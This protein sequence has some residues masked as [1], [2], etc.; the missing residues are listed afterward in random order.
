MAGLKLFRAVTGLAVV[1]A[2]IVVVLG[3]YVRLSAAGLGC[4]DWPGCYG[5][6]SAAQ[7]EA[8]A[9]R[10]AR[11]FPEQP[12]QVDKAAKE[13]LHRYAAGVLGLLVL[14]VALL[15]W[16][17]GRGRLLPLLLVGLLLFQA[18]L[19]MWTVTLLLKPLVVSAHLLGGMALLALLWWMLLD[20]ASASVSARPATL[21][22]TAAG[23][24]LLL[25]LGQILLGGWTS[26]N[27]AGLACGGFPACNGD[28]WP[29]ADYAAAV[30]VT[31][32][33]GPGLVAIH[34]L[35][36]LGALLL[37]LLYLGGLAIVS[38]RNG[39]ALRRIG[40]AIGLLLMLQLALG[41]GNVVT[42]LPLFL[43]AAHNAVAALLLLAMLILNHRL[44]R[45]TG[46]A[47]TGVTV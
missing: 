7:A 17:Q 46:Q 4:P 21:L 44:A 2:L 3:A 19:G 37:L 5:Y 27:Y 16:R 33:N 29:S 11:S 43:A 1:L 15:A 35:H 28:W 30:G 14:A 25:L 18:L 40:W 34:W 41:I 42:G 13:M 24:G 26:A 20:S 12:L 39:P 23:I 22:R 47:R 8:N 45:A 10:I 32:M 6:L 9:E 31:P 36:R 38:V